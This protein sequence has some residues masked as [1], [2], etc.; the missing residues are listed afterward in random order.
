[1]LIFLVESSRTHRRNRRPFGVLSG[2]A[3]PEDQFHIF[4]RD[5]LCRAPATSR[6]SAEI[7]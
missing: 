2:V 5:L 3:I 1:M 4:Q 6:N 7:G